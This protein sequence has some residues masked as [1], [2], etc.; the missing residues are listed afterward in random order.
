[1]KKLITKPLTA[2]QKAAY[3]VSPYHC[4]ACGGD[5]I[6]ADTMQV[7]END[8]EASQ[9]VQCYT[10]QRRWTDLLKVELVGVKE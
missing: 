8:K 1:M 3:I 7:G 10:C 2:K 4:P 6:V 9:R 5:N